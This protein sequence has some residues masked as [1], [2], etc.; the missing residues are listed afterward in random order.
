V[1]P[2]LL[3]LARP[4]EGAIAGPVTAQFNTTTVLKQRI[5]AGEQFDVAVLTQEAIDSL[6]KSGKITASS[7]AE[8]GS[9][10]IGIGVRTGAKKPDVATVQ[11]LKRTLLNAKGITYAA[12]GASRPAI[13]RM[14]E[15]LGIVDSV[16]SKTTLTAGSDAAMA[17]VAGGREELIITLISE[18]MPTPGI[19]LVGPLPARFQ[20]YVRFAAGI[21]TNAKNTQTAKAYLRFLTDP[22]AA[23]TFKAKGIQTAE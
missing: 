23:P 5:E 21:S 18:I 13:E 4:A 2:A 17:R 15:E 8:I 1:R 6:I 22:K 11:A 10:G 14:F 7:R 12:D 9:V 16:T 19:D 3:A 20:R